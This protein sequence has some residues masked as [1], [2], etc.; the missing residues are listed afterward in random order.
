MRS[1]APCDCP[2]AGRSFRPGKAN[3]FVKGTRRSL[4][5]GS[6]ITVRLVRHLFKNVAEFIA[7]LSHRFGLL[8]AQFDSIQAQPNARGHGRTLDDQPK[9]NPRLMAQLPFSP[10]LDGPIRLIE[11]CPNRRRFNFDDDVG[12]RISASNGHRIAPFDLIVVR[13]RV[14]RQKP[15]QSP[16]RRFR[17]PVLSTAMPSRI[18]ARLASIIG[19]GF[20]VGTLAVTR[21]TLRAS[22]V[23][24]LM[25]NPHNPEE[26]TDGSLYAPSSLTF[27]WM[28]AR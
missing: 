4:Q 25:V 8:A 26:D 15:H 6:G 14:A 22:H 11:Q 17:P 19:Q 13:D 16:W 27:F 1:S 3:G 12:V 10:C 21:M 20:V 28:P 24:G 7:S 18:K 2:L 5:G 9:G 23:R